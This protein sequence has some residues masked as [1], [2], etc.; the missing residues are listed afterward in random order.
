MRRTLW[1][2]FVDLAVG[3]L[4]ANAPEGSWMLVAPL[5]EPKVLLAAAA[6]GDG[7]IYAIGGTSDDGPPVNPRVF[8][9][10]PASDSWTQPGEVAPL[11]G[12]RRNM[13]S[14]TAPDGS[15]CV[16]GGYDFSH[17][18][19]FALSIVECYDPS[20]RFWARRADMP[21]G[22]QEPAAATGSDGRIYVM[23]GTTESFATT[24][25]TEA[26]DPSTNTWSTDLAP[27]N[28][29]RTGFGAAAGLDGRIYVFGGYTGNAYVNTAEV[30]DPQEGT[31]NFIAPMQQ[32]RFA[33]A[34]ATGPDGRIYAIGGYDGYG[35]FTTVEAY[36]PDTNT[37]TFVASMS[38]PRAAHAAA[39]GA[40]GRIYAIGGEGPDT[41]RSAEAFTLDSP[42]QSVLPRAKA[43]MR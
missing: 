17:Q 37:W 4:A 1:L 20:F 21:T 38:V 41:G 15:I 27:M 42:P 23:G 22:R 9:Y 30:Y 33:V 2:L 43:R 28:T 6:A 34:G 13:A 36:D 3:T 29:P 39:T 26:Y 31:W 40:D 11:S 7:R 12:P 14:A 10:D 19:P 24:D 8:A 5:P 16:F 35:D 25:V 18:P 32:I